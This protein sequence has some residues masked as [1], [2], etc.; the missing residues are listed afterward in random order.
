VEEMVV[1]TT[2]DLRVILAMFL[3]TF[4]SVVGF[5]L[6]IIFVMFKLS[7]KTVKQTDSSQAFNQP[8]F[9]RQTSTSNQSC[10]YVVPPSPRPVRSPQWSLTTTSIVKELGQGF[11]SKVYLAQDVKHGFVA[12]KT[13]D[14]QRMGVADDCILN[15]ISVLASLPAHLNIIRLVGCNREEKLVVVE[16]CFHG[17]LKDY[18]SR[19]RDYFID[20]LCPDTKEMQEDSFLYSSPGAEASDHHQPVSDF[21]TSIHAGVESPKDEAEAALRQ[22]PVVKQSKSLIKTRRLLYWAYQVSR[23]LRHLAEQGILHRDVALRNILLTNNDVVKIADFGLAV[24]MIAPNTPTKRTHP[25]DQVPQYWSRSNKPAPY[26]WMAPESLQSNVYSQMS[27]V[28]GFGVTLWE[29]FTLGQ[30]PYGDSPT[31]GHIIQMLGQGR[32]LGEASLAPKRV[33]VL[34]RE[35]W[36]SDPSQRPS[37][38]QAVELLGAYMSKLERQTYESRA[39]LDSGVGDCEG[40]LDMTSTR[41]STPSTSGTASKSS[42]RSRTVSKSSA[43]SYLPSSTASPSTN[44]NTSTRAGRAIYWSNYKIMNPS[45]NPLN[46]PEMMKLTKE[47][48]REGELPLI[49]ISERAL[50]TKDGDSWRE[51]GEEVGGRQLFSISESQLDV[52]GRPP[53]CPQSHYSTVQ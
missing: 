53:V 22:L 34:M 9:Q 45:G 20:E 1:G 3:G 41:V 28:W 5:C 31:P 39:R 32:R 24:T 29:L 36:Q 18:V 46:L 25:P 38:Y 26:K 52:C 48:M 14:S 42:T 33:N 15:E 47:E 6:V 19:Y 37:F 8:D 11:Y 21:L 12:L 35:C 7:R 17:N 13:V 2:L 43:S 40:Y 27:D 49:S 4:A 30:E 23:G 51:K 50:A 44:Y 10:R 16:Y